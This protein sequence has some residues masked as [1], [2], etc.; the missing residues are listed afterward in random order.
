M[1]S[2]LFETAYQKA[3]SGK[4][5]AD[6]L[7]LSPST[8]SN[9]RSGAVGISLETLDRLCNYAGFVLVPA[10]HDRQLKDALKTISALWAEAD[11]E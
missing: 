11:K 7:D 10:S 1:I 5:L 9:I 8:V 6:I 3:G 2:D 4:E